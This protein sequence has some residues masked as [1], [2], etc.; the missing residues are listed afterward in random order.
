MSVPEARARAEQLLM[1]LDLQA[2]RHKL[3]KHLS[4]GLKR[5]VLI[6]TALMPNPPILVLDEPTTGL[7]PHAR[8]EVWTML[9]AL[10]RTGTTLLITTHYMEEAEALSD[11]IVVFAH[12]RILAQG[13][14]DEL[15]AGSGHR[16]KA[17]YVDEDGEPRTVYG[18]DQDHVMREI[19]R[20]GA[21]EFSLART[22]LEDLYLQLTSLEREAV[23]C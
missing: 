18:A 15:R 1:E 3:N 6:A 13:T 4:G 14:L 2:H 17:T 22:N 16:F 10:R 9:R 20:I 19:E 11:V 12:G 5:K 23:A 21:A 7:D 8:R